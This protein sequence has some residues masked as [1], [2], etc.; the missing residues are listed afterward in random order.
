MRAGSRPAPYVDS[1]PAAM[2][3][4]ARGICHRAFCI[5]VATKQ[6]PLD[7][8]ATFVNCIKYQF[9][10]AEVTKLTGLRAPDKNRFLPMELFSW[11]HIAP[12]RLMQQP[13]PTLPPIT[14][15]VSED[16]IQVALNVLCSPGTSEKQ[17]LQGSLGHFGSFPAKCPALSVSPADLPKRDLCRCTGPV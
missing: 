6:F 8:K 13:S 10:D 2:Q 15:S 14:F 4:T 17:L 7:L 9:Y 3:R 12:R 16:T 11:L 1:T 5:T